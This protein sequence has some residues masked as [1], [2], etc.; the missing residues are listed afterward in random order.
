MSFDSSFSPPPGPLIPS[1]GQFHSLQV[2][3]NVV[4]GKATVTQA[5]S[6][7]TAVTVNGASGVITGFA[8]TLAADAVESYTVNNSHVSA[9][10]VVIAS[11]QG[12]SGTVATSAVSVYVTDVAEGSFVVNVA[13]GG[14]AALD[15]AVTVGFVIV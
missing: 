12:Y 14:G 10:S 2:N 8:S 5:T 13:N 6:T 11:V 4:V 9:T 7:T 1:D 15:G 3:D